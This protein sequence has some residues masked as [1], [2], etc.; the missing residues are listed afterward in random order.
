MI[1][2]NI[3]FR[4]CKRFILAEVK[5]LR[6]AAIEEKSEQGIFLCEVIE[7]ALFAPEKKLFL[8]ESKTKR[9]LI[10]VFS[11]N[12]ENLFQTEDKVLLLSE[13]INWCNSA[14][15]TNFSVWEI[16][17]LRVCKML[18]D[19]YYKKELHDIIVKAIFEVVTMKSKYEEGV[20]SHSRNK[21]N[22]KR[23][24]IYV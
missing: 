4:K 8:F 1:P 13:Q 14:I 3:N 23:K 22:A 6:M 5:R 15:G 2:D 16:N 7:A 21:M 9:D 20:T 10:S 11:E 17:A 12:R 18:V 19:F 24:N